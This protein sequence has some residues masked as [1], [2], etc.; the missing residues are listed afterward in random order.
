MG[1]NKK[2]SSLSQREQANEEIFIIETIYL[3]VILSGKT[4]CVC[5][6]NIGRWEG[7]EKTYSILYINL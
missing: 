4:N 6:F 3:L 5:A 7:E 1:A 2:L